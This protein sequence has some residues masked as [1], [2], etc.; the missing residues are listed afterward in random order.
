[1][2]N[3]LFAGNK[4]NLHLKSNWRAGINGEPIADDTIQANGE[5]T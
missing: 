1:M 4:R 2:L 5:E 3:Q